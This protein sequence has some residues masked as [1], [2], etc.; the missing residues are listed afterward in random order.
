MRHRREV[1]AMEKKLE[2]AAG[3]GRAIRRDISMYLTY[4]DNC[5][6]TGNFSSNTS[7]TPV[8]PEAS[9]RAEV[10]AHDSKS[11]KNLDVYSHHI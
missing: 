8:R 1:M 6:V 10:G 11:T 2:G 5:N 9:S 7:Q 4:Q 3:R